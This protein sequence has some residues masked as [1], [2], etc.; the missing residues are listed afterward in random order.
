MLARTPIGA[1]VSALKLGVKPAL[2]GVHAAYK[3]VEV[4]EGNTEPA[5]TLVPVPSA[6]VFQPANV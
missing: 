2:L 4:E 5:A 1:V 6:D 3:V